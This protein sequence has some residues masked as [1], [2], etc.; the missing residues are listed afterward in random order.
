MKRLF[1]FLLVSTFFLLFFN[2][3]SAYSFFN[4]SV[5]DMH[6]AWNVYAHQLRYVFY[7]K[8]YSEQFFGGSSS[9]R[10]WTIPLNSQTVMIAEGSNT[11]GN[12]ATSCISWK[13]LGIGIDGSNVTNM[14]F[15]TKGSYIAQAGMSLSFQYD[16]EVWNEAYTENWGTNRQLV[17]T[18]NLGRKPIII[19]NTNGFTRPGD[20]SRWLNAGFPSQFNLKP[21]AMNF[22]ETAHSDT[23]HEQTSNGYIIWHNTDTYNLDFAAYGENAYNNSLFTNNRISVWAGDIYDHG[24]SLLD[25]QSGQSWR[26]I[27]G[28]SPLTFMPVTALQ[29]QEEHKLLQQILTATQQN[30]GQ[31]IVS[32]VNQ[33]TTA[34][35]GVNNRINDL[36][37][38]QAQRQQE[39]MDDD[40]T[41]GET[42]IS[43]FMTT[44]DDGADP[45]LSGIIV[46]PLEF[47]QALT[48]TACT[49]LVLP[50]PFVN[51]DLT[52]P[53]GRAYI[54]QFAPQL[55]ALWDIIAV[56]LIAYRMA[57]HL[58]VLIHEFKNPDNDGNIKPVEL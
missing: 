36:R 40:T 33:T 52:L 39:L 25:V 53:C 29:D 7:I 31:N 54:N 30:N 18:V 37:T 22:E 26:V 51:E 58:F 13:I 4:F 28:K 2:R 8:C 3:V 41:Q 50:L 42:D 15:Q 46:K 34:V 56:G 57:T 21:I 16:G 55:I 44:F 12:N 11:N 17:Q 9:I 35:T 48:T 24:Q 20:V 45:T 10:Q 43:D 19:T 32:A 5:Q 14:T 49:P 6:D 27:L 23:Y 1:T 38:E 47:I